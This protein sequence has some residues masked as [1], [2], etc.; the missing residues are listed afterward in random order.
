MTDSPKRLD[1][2]VFDDYGTC[3]CVDDYDNGDEIIGIGGDEY[4]A[5]ADAESQFKQRYKHDD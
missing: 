3:Y 4:Q 1:R 5:I 2:Q